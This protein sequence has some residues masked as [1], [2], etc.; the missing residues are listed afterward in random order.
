[1]DLKVLDA[2]PLRTTLSSRRFHI[3]G[4]GTEHRMDPHEYY[5]RELSSKSPIQKRF[6][7][8]WANA[9]YD[10]LIHEARRTA[11][12]EARMQLYAEAERLHPCGR[13]H[14]ARGECPH[15][16]CLAERACRGY[17]P[18]VAGNFTY[19]RGGLRTAWL[20]NQ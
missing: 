6:Y 3:S 12:R 2:G 8:A 4:L 20:K 19:N 1:M 17:S 15:P 10:K 18:N 7:S 9:D 5:F 13:A 14:R 11:G 16:V